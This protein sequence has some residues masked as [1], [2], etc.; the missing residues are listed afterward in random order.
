[1]ALGAAVGAANGREEHHCSPALRLCCGHLR[2]GTSF[3]F[4]LLMNVKSGNVLEALLLGTEAHYLCAWPH[5]LCFM[6][7][8]RSLTG[9]GSYE[10][11]AWIALE[12][13]HFSRCVWHPA[14]VKD[15]RGI[16]AAYQSSCLLCC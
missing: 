12:R 4:L 11:H 2:P 1:M 14:L 6:F 13:Q 15:K 8:R 7:P 9:Y 10:E 16:P 5:G 3:P